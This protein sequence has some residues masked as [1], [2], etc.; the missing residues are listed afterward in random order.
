MKMVMTAS[1][2][3]KE[4]WP[5]RLN[6]KTAMLAPC[7]VCC[8]PHLEVFSLLYCFTVKRSHV[9]VVCFTILFHVQAQHHFVQDLAS[10]ADA[11]DTNA[12]TGT[13][14]VAQVEPFISGTFEYGLGRPASNRKVYLFINKAQDQR[15]LLAATVQFLGVYRTDKKVCVRTHPFV[16]YE[17]RRVCRG[18]G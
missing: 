2:L 15:H 1:A 12:G 18:L 9:T 8:F 5:V 6:S 11:K 10:K 16:T 14:T 7:Y 4:S 13:I 17:G 3:R